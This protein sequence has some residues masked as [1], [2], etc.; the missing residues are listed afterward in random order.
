MM[1]SPR[2]ITLTNTTLHHRS[3]TY[4]PFN[5]RMRYFH[6]QIVQSRGR[7]TRV[8]N[9]SPVGAILRRLQGLVSTLRCDGRFREGPTSYMVFNYLDSKYHDLSGYK[10]EVQWIPVRLRAFKNCTRKTIGALLTDPASRQHAAFRPQ[11]ST[12]ISSPRPSYKM[13]YRERRW[14]Q[15]S[16]E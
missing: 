15:Y 8:T 5:Q 16:M 9:P 1:T 14:Y 10:Q 12:L 13:L 4:F 7:G 2:S 6:D 11:A 3:K